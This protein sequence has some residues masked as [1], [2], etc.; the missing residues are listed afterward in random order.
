MTPPSP[1]IKYPILEPVLAQLHFLPANVASDLLETY[2]SDLNPYVLAH[3]LRKRNC[4][5]RT[6]GTQRRTTPALLFAI[7]CVAAHTCNHPYLTNTPVS[8]ARLVQRLFELCLISLRPLQHDEICG[9]GL[10]DVICYIQISVMIAASEFK[11]VS[12]RWFHS[13]IS[14]A[15]ELRFNCET[16]DNSISQDEREERRRSWWL[17]YAMDRHL[18]LCYNRTMAITDVETAGLYQ[19]CDEFHWNSNEDLPVPPSDHPHGPYFLVRGS[20]IFGFF[21]P[22][23]SILGQV[24]ILHEIYQSITL[25]FGDLGH[26]KVQIVQKLE[27]YRISLE[28]WRYDGTFRMYALQIWHAIYILI[29]GKWDVIE[30]I[31]DTDGWI[32]SEEFVT[33]TAQA[34]SAAHAVNHI[35]QIDPDLTLMPWFFGIY[36]LQGSFLILLIVDKLGPSAS[37]AVLEACEIIIRAHESCVVTLD[38]Q[39]QRNFR[40]VMRT[41]LHE[42]TTEQVEFE[43]KSGKLEV[44]KLYRWCGDGRG[45]VV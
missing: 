34:V 43:A 33:A 1:A 36:L 9:G 38:T 41:A 29:S 22:L 35:L 32:S 3:C 45:L 10:D 26:L 12:L 23:M 4:L 27:S 5:A 18:A 21:L 42:A 40:K 7:L 17:L 15:R 25:N 37:P 30:M 11:G 14:L 31:K 20:D 19:P 16:V 8:R 24:V 13:G 39:Y 2:F 6:P 28:N 44:L